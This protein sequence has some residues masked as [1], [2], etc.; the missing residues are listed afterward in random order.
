MI[1]KISAKEYKKA[2]RMRD[3]HGVNHTGIHYMKGAD[4]CYYKSDIPGFKGVE[5]ITKHR[6]KLEK[7]VKENKREQLTMFDD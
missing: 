3:L 2:K 4:N 6:A 7:Y 5:E 1:Y